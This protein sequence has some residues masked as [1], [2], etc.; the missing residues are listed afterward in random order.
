[1]EVHDI[2]FAVFGSSKTELDESFLLMVSKVIFHGDHQNEANAKLFI[3]CY[4]TGS[5]TL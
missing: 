2:K 3:K 4:I 1:M 5:L